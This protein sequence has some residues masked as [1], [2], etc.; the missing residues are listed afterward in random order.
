MISTL[1]AIVGVAVLV[2]AIGLAVFRGEKQA[3]VRRQLWKLIGISVLV[4]LVIGY[5]RAHAP[6]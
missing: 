5:L 6:N 3:K 1:G 2:G 4:L